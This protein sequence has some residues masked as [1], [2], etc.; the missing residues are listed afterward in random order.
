[1][2]RAV[3]RDRGPPPDRHDGI[4]DKRHSA[5]GPDRAVGLRVSRRG[6]PCPHPALRNAAA[7][8]PLHRRHAWQEACGS[9]R[10]EEGHRD[11]G[12]QRVGPATL[13]ETRRM[14]Q[15][16]RVIAPTMN[17]ICGASQAAIPEAHTMTAELTKPMRM[18]PT[19]IGKEAELCVCRRIETA[20]SGYGPLSTDSASGESHNAVEC[21]AQLIRMP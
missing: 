13:V 1:M 8:S 20:I 7:K 10:P 16:G 21:C 4:V 3:R 14:A 17:L 18:G 11:R 6:H 9:R 12:S 19:N 15:T 2:V 5:D